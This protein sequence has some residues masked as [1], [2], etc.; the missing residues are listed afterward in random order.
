MVYFRPVNVSIL[1]YDAG[2]N[3]MKTFRG[4]CF[5]LLV[6]VILPVIGV[7][8]ERLPTDTTIIFKPSGPDILQKKSYEP[9]RNAYGLDL[10]ISNNGFGGGMFYRHE[11]DDLFSGF[12]SLA[13]SD[14]KDEGEFEFY[15]Q[16]TGQLFVPG[17]K[18]RL[19]LIPLVAGVQYRLFKDDIVDNFRPYI[20]AGIG[21][22]M[23]FVSPYAN[24]RRLQGPSGEVFTYSEQIDFFSSLK[25]G[26]AK[27]T[28]GGYIGAGAYFGLDRGTLSGISVRYYIVP[29]KNGIESL[30]NVYIKRF[31][32]FYITL[33]FG[34]LY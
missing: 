18:N 10:L 17:K 13:I 25:Y 29:F 34:S 5:V 7:A 12:V 33:N 19:L 3:S 27:Y 8:Q 4:I 20:T 2:A 16:Y 11:F 1:L 14:V 26:Q 23:V 32:G 31:G 22:S 30:E 6:L 24:T 21:P 28:L 15:D 9:Y